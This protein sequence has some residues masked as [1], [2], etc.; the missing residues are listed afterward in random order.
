[1]EHLRNAGYR[2]AGLHA[3]H[4]DARGLLAFADLLFLPGEIHARLTGAAVRAPF[5]C[6]DPEMLNAQVEVLQRAC[7]E[8]LAL[9]QQLTRAAEER[10]LLVNRLDAELQRL[11]EGCG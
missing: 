6:R 2:L 9:I 5:S 4:T 1:V 10:L 3:I 11:R 7:D 8:R